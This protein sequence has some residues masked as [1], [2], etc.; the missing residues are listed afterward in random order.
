M[1]DHPTA[2]LWR[3]PQ[4]PPQAR[5]PA[6]IWI[7]PLQFRELVLDHA[8]MKQFLARAPQEQVTRAAQSEVVVALPMPDGSFQGFRIVE[9]AVMAP[10][11]AAKFP[12]IKTYAGQG[13]DDPSATLRLDLTAAGFHAQILSPHGAVY[14]DPHLRD[15]SVYAS[16][17]K[18]DYR[19]AADEFECFTPTGET[20]GVRGELSAGLARSGANLRTYRLACAATGE[21]TQFHGGT[22]SAGLAAIV[23]AVNRVTGVYEREL[24]I[25]LVLVANNNLIVYTSASTDPYN[26]G[27]GSTMLGQNQATLDAVIG[28]A[29]YDIGHVFSTGGGGIAGLGVVCVTGNKAR[30]VTGLSAPTGDAFYIDYVA[31]EMGHQ[32]GANHT[33]NSTMGSCGGGNR[34]AATAYEPGSGS[35]IMA[36]AGICG[37]DDLQ[38]N[39]DPYFHSVSFDEILNFTTVG[40]GSVCPVLT[41]TGNTAPTV[42]AG[43]SHTIPRSTPFTLTATG[44]DAEADPLTYGW[45]ERDLGPATTLTASDNGGSPVFRSFNPTTNPSRTFPKLTDILNNT[46]TA[47]EKLPTTSRTLNFR[48]TARDDRAGGGGVNTADTQVTVVSS[49]GPFVILSHNA[50]GTFSGAQTVIWDVAGTAGAPINAANVHILLSTNGGLTFPWVLAANAPNDG[51]QIVVLPN[52]ASSSARIKVEAVG[53]VFFDITDANFSIAPGLPAPLVL[54]DSAVLTTENCAG[55]N[56]AIDPGETVAVNFSLKNFGTADTTNL[57]A[58]LLPG[59]GVVSPSG[60]QAY[61]VLPAGGGAVS[62]SFLFTASGACGGTITN[63]LQLQDGPANLGTVKQAFTLGAM[64]LGTA[65][66]TNSGQINIPANGNKGKATPF[67]STLSVSGVVGTVTKVTVTLRGVNHSWIGDVD[68]LLVGPLGQTVLL[69]S[70]VGDGSATG[71]TVNNLTLTFDD[72]AAVSLPSAAPPASGTFKPTNHNPAGDSDDFSS[73]APAG[74]YGQALSVFSGLNPNG[75]W[76][77]Y[78]Q[79]DGT[80]DT[81]SIAQ[82]WVLTLTSSA[83]ACCSNVN[84]FPIISDIANQ[85]TDEDMPTPAIGFV[86]GDAETPAAALELSGTSSDTN[87]VPHANI[88]FGGSGSNRTV[89]V[90]PAHNAS[91]GATI[92]VTVSDGTSIAGDSFAFTVNPVNDPPELIAIADRTISEGTTLVVTNVASDPDLPAELLTFSLALGSPTGAVMNPTNGVLTWTP[93]LAYAATTNLIVVRVTDDGSPAAFD[94]QTFNVIVMAAPRLV[95]IIESPEG[96]IT[97]LWQAYPGRT[98]RSEFKTNL[99]DSVWATLGTDFVAATSSVATTN[100]AGTNLHG[101]YRLLDVTGP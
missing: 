59:N 90:T 46:A 53:N 65:A 60:S 85:V 79:D 4:L 64:S 28:S 83:P 56:N 30:G 57:M 50:G 98:Y 38:L 74:P 80:H 48:V 42:N 9:S 45:E 82:G 51:S 61:G 16:Y 37:T 95:S 31:H 58:T 93:S 68:A 78:L 33:F 35:T 86:I 66:F 96:F 29:N 73:P 23:T 5:A 22:V 8:G 27:S 2:R 72:N 39:S 94:E 17:Y 47:G 3:Q 52:I 101:F 1:A 54:L 88:V 7:N 41:A 6:E 18:R 36:Y 34:N 63:V 71:D 89:T 20:V 55:A 99:T 92:N 67:P 24:A 11:L 76:A 44:S 25:R 21:Y 69:M 97:L 100:N 43:P 13:L 40:S 14:V 84:A 15:K 77:L 81:G 26:N 70:D 32:F 12:E 10:E 87:L 49:A 75:T 91:G 62:R 19:R